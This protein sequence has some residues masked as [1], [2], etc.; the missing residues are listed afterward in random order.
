MKEREFQA[1]SREL[2]ENLRGHTDCFIV[3]LFWSLDEKGNVIL[4][5]DSLKYDFEEKL[6]EL[7]EIL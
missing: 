2:F 1:K 5:E 3:R 7:R 6:R 4:D